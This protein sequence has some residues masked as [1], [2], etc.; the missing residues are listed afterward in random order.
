[1]GFEDRPEWRLGVALAVGLVVGLERARA[2][3]AERPRRWAGLHSFGL[4][5]LLGGVA[6]QTGPPMHTRWPDPSGR[7]RLTR[8]FRCP[9]LA[10]PC[11][12]P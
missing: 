12:S 10:S 2:R 7:S 4:A 5:S 11:S 8:R 3:D 1:M 6:M 9:K